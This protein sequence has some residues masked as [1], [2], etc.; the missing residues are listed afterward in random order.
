[1]SKKSKQKQKQAAKQ[2]SSAP[3]GVS[4]DVKK[5]IEAL[6]EE[7]KGLADN[8][9]VED[10]PLNASDESK[11]AEAE[12]TEE[13]KHYLKYLQDINH[14]LNG[15]FKYAEDKKA[16]ADKIKQDAQ[17]EKDTVLE[18]KNALDKK[19]EEFNKR[20]Q[21]VLE[22]E[23]QLDNG[24]YT[25][26][27][28]SLLGALTQSEKDISSKTKE[29]IDSLVEK[30]NALLLE[31]EKMGEAS[32][33]IE[34]EKRQI[35]QEN[36]KIERERH[37]MKIDMQIFQEET[38]EKLKAEY[39][40]KYNIEKSRADRLETRN[41]SLE[42]RIEELE[43]LKNNLFVVFGN[44]EPRDILNEVGRIRTEIGQLQEALNSRPTLEEQ[45]GLRNQIDEL[46]VE[47]TRLNGL[48]TEKEI[49]DLRAFINNFSESI[50]K[51]II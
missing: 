5:E 7:V 1:M 22:R 39:S 16:E 13:L 35:A 15:M 18:E 27:I 6:N 21:Q 4:E 8:L 47:N 37:K 31:E 2:V 14:K 10:S 19:H 41:T 3:K 26:S 45:Q 51:Y 29:L 24:E 42:K 38:E 44:R 25:G 33:S 20:E 11:I 9:G 49:T 43:R 12:K 40:D 36:K 30:H 50:D 46:K 23:L 32:M 28:R 17:S 34:E 48:V